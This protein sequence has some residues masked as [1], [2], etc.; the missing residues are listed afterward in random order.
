MSKNKNQS[1]TSKKTSKE[2]QSP[3]AKKSKKPS[4]VNEL[5]QK[6]ETL[7][8]KHL[9]LKAEFDNF[10]RR[11]DKEISGFLQY[12]GENV[13][14]SFLPVLDDIDRL[15]NALKKDGIKVENSIKDGLDLVLGKVDKWLSDLDV[16]AFGET[17]EILD[18]DL[19]DAMM[20]NQDE[21][22]DDNQ[23]MEVF[24]KGYQYKD[25]VIRHAKVIVNKI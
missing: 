15:S 10:R 5:N 8:D 20:T 25:K 22:M 3:K 16:T 19:H 24:E 12:G 4:K 7:Q 14:K 23:I 6:L 1:E 9:R 18:P 2:K 13:I 11:K 17:G 21:K